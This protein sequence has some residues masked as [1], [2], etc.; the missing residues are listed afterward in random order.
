MMAGV[1]TDESISFDKVAS[2]YDA[3]RGGLERGVRFAASIAPFC[4]RTPV[5]EIGI[6][7]GAIALPLRDRLGGAVLGLDLSPAM[8]A[9][10]H[11]R[12]GAT[13][14]VGDVAVLP[15]RSGCV[16]TVV[17]SWILHLVGN[18]A[19]VL[20]EVGRVLRPD[21]RLIV[22]SS[23]GELEPDDIDAVMV[24]LHDEIRG[25]LDISDR[26][27]P[28]ATE[29]GFSLESEFL[30]EAATWNESPLDLVERME[31]RQW[32]VLIDLDRERFRAMVQP[33]IDGLRALPDPSRPRRRIGRHRCFV[34]CQS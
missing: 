15:V 9:H 7:T 33:V 31:R 26:L 34:F 17:A 32:G 16:G 11:G 22:I 21:G 28:L 12:L 19:A 1:S 3:T 18:P 14:G 25:R 2:I 23:R 8:L 4:N 6:G 30:S 13:V 27:V 10:A 24:D 20:D 5:F 29:H